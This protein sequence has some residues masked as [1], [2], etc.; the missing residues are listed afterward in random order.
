[1]M[2]LTLISRPLLLLS[3]S[4]SLLLHIASLLTHSVGSMTWMALLLCMILIHRLKLSAFSSMTL[5][6][7]MY[8]SSNILMNFVSVWII[9]LLLVFLCLVVKLRS[10]V[11]H[12]LKSTGLTEAVLRVGL[13][14]F[15]DVIVSDAYCILVLLLLAYSNRLVLLLNVLIW[16]LLLILLLLLKLRIVVR[17]FILLFVIRNVDDLLSLLPIILRL[18]SVASH[19]WHSILLW[20]VGLPS[21]LLLSPQLLLLLLLEGWLLLND[22]LKLITDAAVRNVVDAGACYMVESVIVASHIH[23]VC[24]YVLQSIVVPHHFNG[25]YYSNLGSASTRWGASAWFRINFVIVP[26][27]N[28]MCDCITSTDFYFAVMASNNDAVTWLHQS[29]AYA[30]IGD[31]DGVCIGV[32]PNSGSSIGTHVLPTELHVAPIWHPVHFRLTKCLSKVLREIYLKIKNWVRPIIDGLTLKATKEVGA[33]AAHK[34]ERIGISC[35]SLM[36]RITSLLLISLTTSMM[37][38][39]VLH[40]HYFYYL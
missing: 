31:V 22:V 33:I 11:S 1:M 15:I 36:S 24:D 7:V 2:L 29:H 3:W 13:K 17:L 12:P 26:S 4:N 32:R 8:L 38:L 9:L 25:V 35:L 5:Y 20:Q 18:I 14:I 30:V 10:P 19:T 39:E 6:V 37:P 21:S 27:N 34:L 28:Q 23:I 40:V 16:V